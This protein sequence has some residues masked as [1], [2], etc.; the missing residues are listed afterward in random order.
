MHQITIQE[1]ES[2]IADVFEDVLRGEEIILT[3]HDKPVV[4]VIPYTSG[5]EP[6]G[7]IGSAKGKIWMAD[8][9][10]ETPEEFEE[11]L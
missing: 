11:Y 2:H 5:N 4:K 10:D 9:F 7:L 1:A 3:D 6:R 8:D